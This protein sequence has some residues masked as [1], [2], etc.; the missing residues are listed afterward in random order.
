MKESKYYFSRLDLT[1][2]L[3]VVFI[4]L[5]A[6]LVILS[7]HYKETV[8]KEREK[9]QQAQTEIQETRQQLETKINQLQQLN[10]NLINKNKEVSELL[11]QQA[12]K[13]TAIRQALTEKE[14]KITLLERQ[15]EEIKAESVEQLAKIQTKL[16]NTQNSQEKTTHQMSTE[17][18]KV[19][20]AL[21]AKTIENTQLLTKQQ[22]LTNNLNQIK[23]QLEDNLT[24]IQHFQESQKSSTIMTTLKAEFVNEIIN[25]YVITIKPIDPENT[26]EGNQ[27]ILTTRSGKEKEIIVYKEK[28][29]QLK[30]FFDENIPH[31]NKDKTFI[32]FLRDSKSSLEYAK[33]VKDYLKDNQ[34]Y[35]KESLAEPNDKK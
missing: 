19:Q 28:K 4:L 22:T 10:F 23:Q 8:I 29:E 35:F 15:L 24:L 7:R 31:Q 27:I 33:W 6:T 26:G 14:E 20:S 21:Q 34:F 16:V 18:A 2:L 17:L 9:F 12:A 32:I 25:T 13:W 5:F 1:P 3:D 11:Q 30:D